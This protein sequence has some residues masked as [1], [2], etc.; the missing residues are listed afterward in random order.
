M[1]STDKKEDASTGSTTSMDKKEDASKGL[2]STTTQMLLMLRPLMADKKRGKTTILSST[3]AH[4]TTETTTVSSPTAH[5][6]TGS[7]VPT[8]AAAN[9]AAPWFGSP[10]SDVAAVVGVGDATSGPLEGQ[11]PIVNDDDDQAHVP[12][13]GMLPNA[14]GTGPTGLQP[15]I[16]NGEAALLLE[17]FNTSYSPKVTS[18]PEA[19]NETSGEGVE[20]VR[21][22]D[23]S[24]QLLLRDR[25]LVLGHV[26]AACAA[27]ATVIVMVFH[28]F[29]QVRRETGEL[30]DRVDTE[31]LLPR[32]FEATRMVSNL[33]ISGSR[34]ANPFRSSYLN[35]RSV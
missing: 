31:M 2:A 27:A 29:R 11:S 13:S 34:G 22:F 1:T 26:F 14:T 12:S 24:A 21:K 4:N 9:Q 7:A 33:E 16:Q 19:G 23:V 25:G 6:K 32:H 3:T 10:T 30:D 18:S 8:N 28:I 17:A 5:K 20:I 35:S 15:E